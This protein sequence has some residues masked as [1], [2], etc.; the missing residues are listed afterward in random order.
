METLRGFPNLPAMVRDEQS[1]ALPTRVYGNPRRL[2]FGATTP[3]LHRTARMGTRRAKLGAPHA[4]LWKPAAAGFRS[5]YPIAAQDCAYGYATGTEGARHEGAS[6]WRIGGKVGLEA[7]IGNEVPLPQ[8]LCRAGSLSLATCSLLLAAGPAVAD[9][10]PWWGQDKALHFSACLMLAGDAY[11]TT[12]VL[13]KRE[14]T[15]LAAGFGVAVA[16]GAAKEVYDS[17]AG[18]DASL[19]DMTWDVVGGAT[20]AAISWI[21]DRYLF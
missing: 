12:A 21:I 9:T 10:D 6:G 3:S 1:S 19:R 15:R 16:A 17:R 8:R 13:S 4:S 18:G 14:T 7:I 11:A 5:D 2:V 20:G